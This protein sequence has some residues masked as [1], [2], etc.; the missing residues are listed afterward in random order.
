MGFAAE[1]SGNVVKKLINAYIYAKLA[2]NAGRSVV[3]RCEVQAVVSV[4]L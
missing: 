2:I 4:L 3:N 1:S